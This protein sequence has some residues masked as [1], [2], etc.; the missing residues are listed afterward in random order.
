MSYL[1][2]GLWHRV[3]VTYVNDALVL[4]GET[5]FGSDLRCAMQKRVGSAS[6]PR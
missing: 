1:V 3:S 2:V 6:D 5:A 4:T